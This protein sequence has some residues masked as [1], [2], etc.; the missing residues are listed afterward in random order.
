MHALAIH[1]NDEHSGK[2]I[3]ETGSTFLV[4]PFGEEEKAKMF[5]MAPDGARNITSRYQG[6]ILRFK[7]VCLPGFYRI[8]CSADQLD[9]VV[10]SLMSVVMKQEF[11]YPP[12]PSLRI[13]AVNSH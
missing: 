7:N 3:F 12:S 5:S 9:Q 8:L 2:V 6:A 11:R 10:Q 4:G 13:F 1:V